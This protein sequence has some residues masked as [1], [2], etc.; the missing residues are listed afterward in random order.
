VPSGIFAMCWPRAVV[1][2]SRVK[3]EQIFLAADAGSTDT[4]IPP[5]QSRC[6]TRRRFVEDSICARWSSSQGRLPSPSSHRTVLVLFT[7]GSSG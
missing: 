4:Q 1:G 3:R 6:R 7:Y 5:A 2:T